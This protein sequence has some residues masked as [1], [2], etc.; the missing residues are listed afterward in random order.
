MGR[1]LL[2]SATSL[3]TS[4]WTRDVLQSCCVLQSRPTPSA[5]SSPSWPGE[6]LVTR[7]LPEAQ[8]DVHSGLQRSVL[9]LGVALRAQL[10]FNRLSSFCCCQQPFP[11]IYLLHFPCK[12]A[13]VQGTLLLASEY[14]VTERCTLPC[15]SSKISQHVFKGK[16]SYC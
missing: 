11:P 13:M 8:R 4:A 7:S 9:D 5:A 15:S 3:P 10:Q 14:L 12:T 2:H 16:S 6:L 1:H